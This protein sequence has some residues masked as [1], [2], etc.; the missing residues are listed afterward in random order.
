MTKQIRANANP[1]KEFFIHMITRDVKLKEAIVEL[2][3][4]SIDGAQR[5]S[6]GNADYSKLFIELTM[7]EDEFVI[8]DN[9]GGIDLARARE[10]LFRFGRPRSI[11]T[12]Q[13]ETTSVFGIGMKRTIL[14]IGTF[15]E[16][17]STAKDSSF[18]VKWDVNEWAE[19]DNPDW[20]IPLD[21]EERPFDQKDW[22]TEITIRN[23]FD[24]V[25]V[26][27]ISSP[28]IA[29]LRNHIARRVSLEIQKGLTI[30]INGDLLKP[31]LIN[32][33]NGEIEPIKQTHEYKCGDEGVVLI[34]IMVGISN[35]RNPREAGWYIY[36]NDR[37]IL[38]AD[39]SSLT[40]W[41]D[42]QAENVTVRYHN[43]YASFRGFAYFNSKNPS[44]LPWNTTKTSLD[45]SSKVYIFA[46]EKMISA[47]R[48]ILNAL[49]AVF[50]HG[51]DANEKED[52]QYDHQKRNPFSGYETIQVTPESA[53][54]KVRVNADV[55]EKKILEIRESDPYQTISYRKRKS[56]IGKVKEYA[57][58][59]SNREI[60]ELTFDYYLDMEGI[61]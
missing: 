13:L 25:K 2:V 33:L 56:V 21:V 24:G 43:N 53:R 3:G 6:G 22:G 36:C 47:A 37:L 60:G 17:V 26:D 35:E 42:D 31:L 29:E 16:I 40:T 28:F 27:F 5:M 39:K 9:C 52:E 14:K 12:E 7:N 61:E 23:I 38:S 15:A 48:K 18:T 1:S 57:D 32:V 55:D 51:S 20:D 44:L 11:P 19:D 58:K 46:K 59:R 10:V 45:T 49:T 34:T 41:S 30:K 50:A 8:R 54:E 4:N